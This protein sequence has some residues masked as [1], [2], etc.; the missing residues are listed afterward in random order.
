MFLWVEGPKGLDMKDIYQTAINENVGFVPGKYFF[1]NP[2]DGI[3]TM[4]LNFTNVSEKQIQSAIQTL[5]RI[6]T[7]GR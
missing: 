6:I 3:E 5:G 1:P 4:R 2:E 7:N